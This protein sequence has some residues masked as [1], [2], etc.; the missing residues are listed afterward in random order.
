MTYPYTTREER[1]LSEKHA[2][3]GGSILL[4]LARASKTHCRPTIATD[5]TN[6]HT[7]K[8]KSVKDLASALGLSEKTVDSY[9]RQGKLIGKYKIEYKK[10]PDTTRE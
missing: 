6:G 2:A 3:A 7:F 1:T 10:T 5:T 9:L 4:N 8:Y